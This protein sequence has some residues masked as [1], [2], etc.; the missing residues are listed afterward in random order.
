M[1]DLLQIGSRSVA[2]VALTLACSCAVESSEPDARRDVAAVVEALTTNCSPDQA[3]FAR[4]AA[5]AAGMALL[6]AGADIGGVEDGGDASRFDYW[7]GAH[8]PENI[9]VVTQVLL[10]S[11]EMIATAEFRCGCDDPDPNLIAQTITNDPN[12]LIRL[13]P[14][15]FERDFTE[16]AVG[17]LIHELSHLNGT[18]HWKTGAS[19]FPG[20]PHWPDYWHALTSNPY[21]ATN[22]AESYRLYALDWQPGE[23]S[24]RGAVC[25]D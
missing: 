7:F 25:T 5:V 14:P 1:V 17:G 12:Q 24:S 11:Y 6:G 21:G 2:L 16:F 10:G 8:E 20:D 15:F 9:R 4:A 19:C 13:C 18:L 23:A 3:S 22:N